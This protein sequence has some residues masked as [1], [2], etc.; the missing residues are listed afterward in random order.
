[1]WNI[2]DEENCQR[3]CVM[4]YS[5]CVYCPHNSLNQFIYLDSHMQHSKHCNLQYSL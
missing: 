1:M 4:E 5:S 3:V 2:P